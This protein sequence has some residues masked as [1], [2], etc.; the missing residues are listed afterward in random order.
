MRC[1]GCG[2][3]NP[4]NT[5]FCT[6]CGASLGQETTRM[7]PVQPPPPAQPTAQ[8]SAAPVYAPVSQAP[9][10]AKGSKKVWIALIATVVGL[11]VVAAAIVIPLL[12]IA[13][14]KPVAQVTSVSLVR[15]DGD[16]LDTAKVPLDTELALK[17]TYKS[18]FKDTGSGTLRLVVVDAA[19]EN[20]VDKTYDV[21][22]SGEPQSKDLKFSM[23]QGSGK[24][25]HA[26]ATLKV[27]QGATKLNAAK[28]LAF[29]VVEGK[30]AA[31]QLEE[32]TA[33]AT[34]KAREATDL[35]KSTAAQGINV[36]D[37]VERLTKALTDLQAAKTAAEA[38]AVTATA[39]GVIDECNARVAAAAQAAKNVE[40]CRQNQAVV[41]AKLVD[42]WSGTGNFPD[43]MSQL[44][45]LP[46][47]PSGGSYTYNAP[48]TTPATL[49]ISCSV[50]G[51]L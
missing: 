47:C 41:R 32:A 9:V 51:E 18:K 35:L 5:K 16:T 25:I 24:E 50:H 42:W 3:D 7:Q 39:Q 38:N 44:S 10:K 17:V 27:T 37:L 36:T 6:S 11:C 1:P 13:A 26:K 23:D 4:S 21:K 30:G 15:T 31:V 2:K 40:T 46:T 49:H 29:T 48:D 12:V 45:G 34:K 33:A 22:S 8:I 28:T 20:I 14:N 19:G 43:S